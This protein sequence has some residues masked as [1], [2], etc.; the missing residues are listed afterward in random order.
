[1]TDAPLRANPED[2]PL[3]PSGGSLPASPPGG[4]SPASAAGGGA[5]DEAPATTADAKAPDPA[6]PIAARP[7]STRRPGPTYIRPIGSRPRPPRD[8]R[9]AWAGFLVGVAALAV[10]IGLA[11]LSWD[12]AGAPRTARAP[13]EQL[14]D[15]D[16]A[17]MEA[18]L[19]GLGFPPG[20]IDG[21]IDADT[22]TAI[23]D[24]QAMAGLTVDGAPSAG[25]LEELRAAH[26]EL[27][28][29]Q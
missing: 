3:P 26:L 2:R 12:L 28:G 6:G 1:M 7:P 25:L 20:E 11:W 27:N 21:E 24:F 18:L 17:E 5:P 22:A 9:R 19:D 23:R 16:L 8:W 15:I 13:A 29:G 10:A 14:P 4:A